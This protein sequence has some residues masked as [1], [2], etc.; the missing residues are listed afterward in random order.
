MDADELQKRR[1]MLQAFQKR[2]PYRDSGPSV[3]K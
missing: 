3:A 1:D 2:Q